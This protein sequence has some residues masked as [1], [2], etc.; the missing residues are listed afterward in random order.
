[1][2]SKSKDQRRAEQTCPSTIDHKDKFW[3]S[4]S[5]IPK[6]RWEEI[7]GKKDKTIDRDTKD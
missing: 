3:A 1:V 4:F 2:E 5:H 6:K 7:F